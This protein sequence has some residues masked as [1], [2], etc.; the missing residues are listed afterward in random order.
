MRYRPHVTPVVYAVLLQA[1]AAVA[2]LSAGRAGELTQESAP[3][4]PD[5]PESASRG[6]L[7]R[8]RREARVLEREVRRLGGE[9]AAVLAGLAS[10]TASRDLARLEAE[11]AAERRD[12]LQSELSRA[13]REED[14]ARRRATEAMQALRS[15][16]QALRR[17]GPAAGLRG[18]LASPRPEASLAAM[19]LVADRAALDRLTAGRARHWQQ[20]AEERGRVLVARRTQAEAA[21]RRWMEADRRAADAVER[22]GR[23]LQTVQN[24]EALYRRAAG[25]MERA[26]HEMAAFLAGRRA[27]QPSGPD[28]RALMG[29]LRWPAPGT[30]VIGFGPRQHPRFG[31]ETP[32]NGIA[33]AAAAGTPVIATADGRVVYADWFQGYGRTVIL[34]HGSG[35]MTVSAHLQEIAAAF[36]QDV[37]RGERLGRVGDSGTLEGTHLYF[38]LRE[39]GRP[40]PPLD[41][42]APRAAVH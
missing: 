27:E 38:E 9:G 41:W 26:A 17:R 4:L 31:T 21:H 19:R 32:H 28:P 5:G 2:P 36:G 42:L 10:L 8:L 30:M 7:E 12:R 40:V 20:E 18:V 34:D 6:R 13:Q 15:R 24:Q 29:T 14:Q 25:E 23:R 35:I 22:Q 3:V 39:N 33:I 37:G 16:L 11:D 1:L